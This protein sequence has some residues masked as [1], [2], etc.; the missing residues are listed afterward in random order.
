ME[1]SSTQIATSGLLI[2]LMIGLYLII[3][4]TPY[5]FIFSKAGFSKWLS[6]LVVIPV[7]SFIVIYVVAFSRR[8]SLD[9]KMDT[10]QP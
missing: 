7:V 5:W 8:P 4:I 3:M 6:F 9:K 10:S 1:E 2:A